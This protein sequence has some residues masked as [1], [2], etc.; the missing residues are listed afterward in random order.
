[1]TQ[2]ETPFPAL[3]ENLPMRMKACRHGTVLYNIHDTYIGRGFDLYGEYAESEMSFL[4]NF[5][6]PGQFVCDIGANI[7]AHTLFFAKTVGLQGRVISF[8]PQRQIFQTLCA[9]VT[10]NALN[11][12]LTFHAGAGEAPGTTTVPLLNY[13]VEGNFG[14]VSL[15]TEHGETVQI[16]ALDQLGLPT[17]SLIKIDVEGME[18]AVLK[19]AAQTISQHKPVLYVENDRREKSPELIAHIL[20]LGYRAY[21]HLAPLYSADN[22]AGNPDNIFGNTISLNMLCLASDIPQKIEGLAEIQ[23]PDDFPI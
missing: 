19:G 23:T 2:K 12:V 18:L 3:F 17:V 10:L 21:W 13:D 22:F 8:E 14:G 4:A 5:I 11:N 6:H 1:M 20:S 15:A 9:N 16:M 7:G